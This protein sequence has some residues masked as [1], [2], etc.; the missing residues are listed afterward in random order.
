MMI[1]KPIHKLIELSYAIDD[2]ETER[3]T[4]HPMLSRDVFDY[5]I[6]DPHWDW[7]QILK[8]IDVFENGIHELD[9]SRWD[10]LASVAEAY[11]MM[12]RLGLGEKVPYQEIVKTFLQMDSVEIP[13]SELDGIRDRLCEKLAQA[14][15]PD[16]LEHGLTQWKKDQSLAFD[17]LNEFGQKV[18]TEA[19]KRVLDMNIGLPEE[20]ETQLNF[21][22]D[23]PFRGYS[24]Y[25]G[26]FR[27][28]I[29]L[30]GD[31]PWEKPSL[32]HTIIHESFPGHQ[33][34]SAVREKLFN[35][36]KIDIETTI[37]FY[38]TGISTIHEGQC[39]LGK[40]MIGMHD[41]E[42]DLIQDLATD[43]INGNETNL[44]VAANEGRLDFEKGTKLLM[45]RLYMDE[46]LASVRYKYFTNPLW[47]TCFPHYYH[48]RKFIRGQ[49]ERMNSRGFK[50]EY[51]EM[52]YRHPHTMRTLDKCI[53]DFLAAH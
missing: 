41:H 28:G 33:T 35:Q 21:P 13:Q 40:T 47:K 27:G 32:K 43:Y 51:A 2:L 36:G 25:D 12:A 31:T 17:E 45:E 11:R 48:G 37:S 1:E 15:Y 46:K 22:H 38:N 20:Q 4:L 24:S 39:D 44:A 14:G 49:Y 29:W 3:T 50:M 30:N 10:Y 52:V 9:S 23:F 7:S 18:M 8:E 26:K 6:A 5:G 42:N 53:T 19:R 34:F 16:D